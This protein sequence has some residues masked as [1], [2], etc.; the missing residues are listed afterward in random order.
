MGD[1]PQKR[2]Q[3][4]PTQGGEVF[5]AA[6]TAPARIAGGDDERMARIINIIYIKNNLSKN[7]FQT[8]PI[9]TTDFACCAG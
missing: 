2:E 6:D 4:L 1:S 8:V 7:C 9:L 5:D 3:T